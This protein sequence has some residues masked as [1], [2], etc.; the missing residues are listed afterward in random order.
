MDNRVLIYKDIV[1]TRKVTEHVPNDRI[2]LSL[3]N[4]ETIFEDNIPQLPSFWLRLKDYIEQTGVKIVKFRYQSKAYG[5]QEFPPNLPYYY[6]MKRQY[7][8]VG[9][10][11]MQD[12][13]IGCSKDGKTIEGFIIGYGEVKPFK[14][15]FDKGGIGIIKNH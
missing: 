12:I 10:T 15:S 2:I 6:Y 3:S 14:I 5:L 9:S 11:A 1:L 8:I 7:A 13:K 4:G